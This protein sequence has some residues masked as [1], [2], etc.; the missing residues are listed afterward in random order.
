MLLWNEDHLESIPI[1]T[2]Q[3]KVIKIKHPDELL[4]QGLKKG[5]MAK[6]E[7][8][9]PR[10]EICSGQEYRNRVALNAEKLGIEL[11]GNQI[12]TDAE[13]TMKVESL[14]ANNEP[15]EVLKRFSKIRTINEELIKTG[16]EIL[17]EK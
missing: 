7:I 14:P 10:S 16:I 15:I 6:V 13:E 5:D 4:G 1:D 3:K 17:E 12:K 8:Y 11:Y 2:I 9:L